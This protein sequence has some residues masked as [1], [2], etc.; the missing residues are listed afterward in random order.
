[1]HHPD[2][3]CG[4]ALVEAFD[5]DEQIGGGSLERLTMWQAAAGTK[6]LAGDEE[7]V[8]SLNGGREIALKGSGCVLCLDGGEVAL[9]GSVAT[10][11]FHSR[12][13]PVQELEDRKTDRSP[14]QGVDLRLQPCAS[15]PTQFSLRA[16]YWN[17]HSHNRGTLQ[18]GA[19]AAGT[20]V[21]AGLEASAQ[22]RQQ[23]PNRGLGHATSIGRNAFSGA[24]WRASEMPANAREHRELSPGAR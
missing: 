12:P 20:L 9:G 15:S 7:A 16:A 5:F 4:P 6:F 17:M 3:T 24:R 10:R 8:K 22:V 13:T 19:I 21:R 11:E 1:M 23:C 14:R 2:G 18:Q